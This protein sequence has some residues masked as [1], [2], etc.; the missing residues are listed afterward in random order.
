[1][2]ESR[3]RMSDAPPALLVIFA[4]EPAPGR[5]K[6]RLCPPLTPEQAAILYEQFLADVLAEMAP[7]PGLTL[8][9]AYTA[10]TATAYFARLAPMA[11]LVAQQGRN[12]GERLQNAFAWGFQGGFSPILIRNS[13]SPDLPGALVSAAREALAAGG[14][15]VALGP[16]PDGGYYLVG[17]NRFQP[18]LFQGIAWSTEQ[19]LAQT[20][21]GARRTGLAV[22]LL[23]PWPDLDTWADLTAF[24]RRAPAWDDPGAASRR[25][26]RKLIGDHGADFPDRA[27][28]DLT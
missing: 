18:H 22:H 3:G 23:P 13:D 2:M 20:L 24:A 15:D 1:M 19:V 17:L 12:L 4:K 6:T 26:A 9:L 5:V 25:L 7:L 16:C 27:P 28:P 21:E 14:A 11:Q 8:A 10:D